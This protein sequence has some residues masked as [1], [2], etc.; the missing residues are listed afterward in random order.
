MLH[1]L[2]PPKRGSGSVHPFKRR[3]VTMKLV[4]R[5]IGERIIVILKGSTAVY[6]RFSVGKPYGLGICQSSFYSVPQ[7]RTSKSIEFSLLLPKV[8]GLHWLFWACLEAGKLESSFQ[9]ILCAK[10][11]HPFQHYT[12]SSFT[13]ATLLG[14]V[15]MS[16]GMLLETSP[17]YTISCPHVS[18]TGR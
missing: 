12:F 13:E 2:W 9:F 7:K 18:C 15:T 5:P 10:N 1:P 3:E 11:G 14:D 6:V 8:L 16:S 17:C 4:A